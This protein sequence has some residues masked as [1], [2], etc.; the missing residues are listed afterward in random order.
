MSNLTT[1]NE[2]LT[3]YFEFKSDCKESVELHLINRYWDKISPRL[4]S[5]KPYLLA[6]AKKNEQKM[7]TEEL[8]KRSTL[9]DKISKEDTSFYYQPINL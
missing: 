6:I 7:F 3:I 4:K 9:L 1:F 8:S 5:R 2:L